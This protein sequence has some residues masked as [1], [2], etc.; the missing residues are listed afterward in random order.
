MNIESIHAKLTRD[1]INN[2]I[3]VIKEEA[4]KRYDEQLS[5][6][7]F[8]NLDKSLAEELS[9]NTFVNK[10]QCVID[11]II[12]DIYEEHVEEILKNL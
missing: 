10:Y 12:L 9:F 8:E 4:I 7:I 2:Q 3:E 5:R 6:Y 1:E 11:N